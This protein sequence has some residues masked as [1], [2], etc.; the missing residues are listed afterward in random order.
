MPIYEPYFFS[1]NFIEFISRIQKLE[2]GKIWLKNLWRKFALWT[3]IQ[4][5]G[6]QA[7][8]GIIRHPA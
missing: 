1:V 7:G 2:S 6:E 8:N 3:D 5:M 4:H